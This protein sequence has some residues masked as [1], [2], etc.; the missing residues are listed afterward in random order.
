VITDDPITIDLDWD[1]EPLDLDAHSIGPSGTGTFHDYF[2]DPTYEVTTGSGPRKLA[3]SSTSTIGMAMAQKSFKSTRTPGQYHYY[4]VNYSGETSCANGTVVTIRDTRSCRRV[5][6]SVSESA[7]SPDLAGW[8]DCLDGGADAY[9]TVPRAL[10][11]VCWKRNCRLT[12]RRPLS[13]ER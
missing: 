4:V 1:A 5:V 11:R 3:H 13:S 10:S 12:R 6:R 9:T 7:A 8:A 2:G